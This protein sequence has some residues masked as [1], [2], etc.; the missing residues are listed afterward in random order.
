MAKPPRR[1]R[2]SA[3]WDFAR[4]GTSSTS[5]I[6]TPS[7]SSRRSW[8]RFPRCTRDSAKRSATAL[9]TRTM[10]PTPSSR[11]QPSSSSRPPRRSS[12][13]CTFFWTI[14]TRQPIRAALNVTLDYLVANLPPDHALRDPEP[15][16][17]RVRGRQAQAGRA[18]SASSVSRELRFGPDQ[19]LD[20]VLTPA[21]GSR[22]LTTAQAAARRSD[23]GLARER[24][25]CGAGRRGGW[26]WKRLESALFGSA[27][28]AGRLLVPRRAGVLARVGEK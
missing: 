26:A 6:K 21:P 16:R 19:V 10:S 15:L 13:T 20:V 3:G 2:P 4:S 8:R 11:W 18:S 7:H 24:R 27:P 9:P 5:S 28:E 22:P 1:S 25:P 23:R 14:T 12:T 17:A